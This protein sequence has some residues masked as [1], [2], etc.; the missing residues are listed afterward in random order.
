MTKKELIEYLDKYPDDIEIT[1]G[2]Y[3]NDFIIEE[4]V[5]FGALGLGIVG[6]GYGDD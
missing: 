3:G 4:Y 1:V 2:S 6:D 5:R